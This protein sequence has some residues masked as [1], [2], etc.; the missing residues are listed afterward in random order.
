ME[1]SKTDPI[2]KAIFDAVNKLDVGTI[3]KWNGVLRAGK[4]A[5]A[6]ISPYVA[7]HP[8]GS[9]L[10]PKAPGERAPLEDT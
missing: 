10:I 1:T 3:D 9:G 5:E 4:I 7:G 6:Y 2:V 8:Y